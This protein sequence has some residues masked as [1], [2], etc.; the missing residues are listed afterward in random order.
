MVSVKMLILQINWSADTGEGRSA[1]GTLS[2][3]SPGLGTFDKQFL[4]KCLF[5]RSI[6]AQVQA[7]GATFMVHTPTSP[8]VLV[9]LINSF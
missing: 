6:G 1:R 2:H 3:Q 8:L 5:F 9:P 4:L 7:K